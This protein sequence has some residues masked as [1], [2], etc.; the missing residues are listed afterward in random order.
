MLTT[1]NAYEVGYNLQFNCEMTEP[2]VFNYA[3]WELTPS[4]NATTSQ[5]QL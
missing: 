2:N 4:F 5:D 1:N 3:Y